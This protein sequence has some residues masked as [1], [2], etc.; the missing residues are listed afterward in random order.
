MQLIAFGVSEDHGAPPRFL[1]GWRVELNAACAQRFVAGFDVVRPQRER[2]ER[3]DYILVAGRGEPE[4]VPLDLYVIDALMPDLVGH[5]RR[6]SA[7]LLFLY[8]W[9]RTRG[10]VKPAVVSYRMMA[11][12]TGLSKRSAQVALAWLERRRLVERARAS[13]TAATSIKLR[14]DWRGS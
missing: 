6:A 12:G 1:L 3:A 4:R 9:R 13:P 11:D 7:F 10:G 2:R 8:L 14:C 5:D